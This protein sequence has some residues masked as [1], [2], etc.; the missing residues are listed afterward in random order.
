MGAPPAGM[1]G[2]KW[3]LFPYRRMSYRTKVRSRV[4]RW[5][6]FLSFLTVK[7]EPASLVS[8]SV[9]SNGKDLHLSRLH[10]FGGLVRYRKTEIK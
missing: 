5:C 10:G 8:F 2:E 9:L 4:D 1:G 6:G 7:R 3:R